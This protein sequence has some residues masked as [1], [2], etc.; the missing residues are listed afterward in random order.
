LPREATFL[1]SVKCD[2]APCT[3]L[4][5]GTSTSGTT[6]GAKNF[7]LLAAVSSSDGVTTFINVPKRQFVTPDAFTLAT[8]PTALNPSVFATA[9]TPAQADPKAA[10]IQVRTDDPDHPG[11]PG[12][13]RNSTWRVVWHGA[14]AGL[15]RRAGTL[16][17]TGA[18]TVRFSTAPANLNLWTGD[19]VFN[20]GAGD[21]ATVA[22]ATSSNGACN[23]VVNA[24]NAVSTTG[25]EFTITATTDATLDLEA[26]G[27]GPALTDA[28]PEIGVILEVR[29]GG[30]QP[31]LVY[32]N[33]ATVA[34]W[35][36]GET[37][38]ARQI[39]YDYPFDVCS[40]QEPPQACYVPDDPKV[41]DST[42]FTF[43]ITGNDPA[44]PSTFTISLLE[45]TPTT[46]LDATIT[47]G[48]ANG[49]LPYSS[50]RRASLLFVSMAGANE[51]LQLTPSTLSS[52]INGILA[53]R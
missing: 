5:L 16:K 25:P 14:M 6:I 39:R 20:L 30:A 50:P 9:L 11:I 33:D 31:W 38:V 4:Y 2:V 32:Q 19:P 48:L 35:H 34:R 10:T 49:I 15:E 24:F 7:D 43:L 42:A 47:G 21:A 23:D 17:L 26:P 13:A 37:F 28:C 18:G 1:R 12:V 22:T 41:T 8:A 27:S 29:T 53:Y 40:D 46:V 44:T 36:T 51:I 52:D 45:S 3:P